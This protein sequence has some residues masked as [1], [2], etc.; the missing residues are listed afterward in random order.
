MSRNADRA[1]L[2]LDSTASL[3]DQLTQ[4]SLLLAWH[5]ETGKP[6]EAELYWRLPRLRQTLAQLEE[7]PSA[8]AQRPELSALSDVSQIIGSTLDL[9]EV[10][11]RVMDQIVQLTGAERAILMLIDPETGGLEC[12]AARN[13][14]HETM[15]GSAFEISRSI[16]NEVAATGRPVV[17]TNAQMDPRFSAQDS[18]VGYNLRS[19]LCVPLR[20]RG[21]T[22]GVIYADSRARSGL[23]SDRE[24][25]LL[26]TFASQ[27]AVSIENARLFENIAHAKTLMDNVFSSVASGL[28]T[29]DVEDRIGLVNRAARRILQTPEP[30]AGSPFAEAFPELARKLRRP[31]QEVKADRQPVLGF[32]TKLALPDRG[33]LHL[34]VNLSPLKDAGDEVQGIA[35]V[36]DDLTEQ[37]RLESRYE[38]FQRY[39]S[40][41]VIERLPDDP[42]QLRLGGQ[43][44]EIT[45]LFAD[46]R[47]FTDFSETHDPEVLMDVLNQHLSIGAEAVLA[48][49]GTLDK[50]MG[51][52]V[53]AFFNAP[54]PQEDHT[55]RALRAAWRIQQRVAELHR[56]QPRAHCLSYGVGISLGEAVVGNVGTKQ[57]LDYTAIGQTVNLARRLQEAAAP[58]Q[59]L[60][61][62]AVY[63]RARGHVEARLLPPVDIEGIGSPITAYEL[64]GLRSVDSAPG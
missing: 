37:R 17:T 8:P 63:E 3:R 61:S 57:R 11:S 47:G 32:E 4:L 51:D 16:V 26:T 30:H 20:V 12:R 24:R 58:G 33:W 19:I 15:T 22:T 50:F 42:Q 27:A 13:V 43:R 53:V 60:I 10:L 49:D 59:V 46:I 6:V 35:I 45:S 41:A 44:Q 18:I 48:E 1:A 25:D 55:L 40:P 28:I 21:R 36:L 39:L 23:F 34:R 5:H 31:L 62:D 54:L 9:P 52:A 14:D 38:L 64:V 29:T 7:Q 56:Q 2:N